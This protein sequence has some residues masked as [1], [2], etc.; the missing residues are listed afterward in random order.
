MIFTETSLAGAYVVTPEPIEDARGFFARSFSRE[1]F[2]E[3][4]LETRVVQCSLSFNRRAGTL[5]G[6]HYQRAPHGEA[7]F[8][9]CTRGSL[10]DVI[11]DLRAGSPTFR[12]WVGVEL[13]D[14]NRASLYVPRGFAHGFQTLL[15]ETEVFYM[16]SDPHVPEAAT[17]VRWDDPTFGIEWPLGAPT[18]I[19]EKDRAWPDLVG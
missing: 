13:T 16:I 17:G 15:D 2:A 11:V 12:S 14:E 7:K 18:E 10:F 5:R 9:R 6:L 1:E 3:R 19:S 4:K 8:V